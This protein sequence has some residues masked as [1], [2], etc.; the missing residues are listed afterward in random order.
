MSK[1]E[2]ITKYDIGKMLVSFDG[3]IY[4]IHIKERMSGDGYVH[5]QTTHEEQ[6]LLA[7][8]YC[9]TRHVTKYG[10]IGQA[11]PAESQ[12]EYEWIER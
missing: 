5:W 6:I 11:M 3:L 7:K 4:R 2:Q 12:V 1:T 9:Y 8:V 10:A